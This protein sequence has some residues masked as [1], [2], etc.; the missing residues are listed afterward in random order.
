MICCGK[1]QLLH[2]PASN[3]PYVLRSQT[4]INYMFIVSAWQ[5]VHYIGTESLIYNIYLY[6]P[7]TH[8]IV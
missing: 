5:L 4:L 1:S 6:Y 7:I 8:N 3:W 2:L